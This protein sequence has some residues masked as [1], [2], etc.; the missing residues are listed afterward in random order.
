S[1]SHSPRPTTT[2]RSRASCGCSRV[3]MSISRPASPTTPT[4]SGRLRST[5]GGCRLSVTCWDRTPTRSFSGQSSRTLEGGRPRP[6]VET[7]RPFDAPYLATDPEHQGQLLH[8]VY[9]RP[10]GWDHVPP[11]REVPCGESSLWGDH[12]LLEPGADDPPHGREG[13]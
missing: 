12:H 7:A 9:H 11:G 8:G 10:D 1:T 6:R 2:A 3:D 4:T 13:G 5:L